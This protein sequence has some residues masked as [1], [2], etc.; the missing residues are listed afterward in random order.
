V[1]LP[2][3]LEAREAGINVLVS[4]GTPSLKIQMKKATKINARYVVMVGMMEAS[5]GI[6][7]VRDM[8]E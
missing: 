7:Q 1:V 2:L 8:L 5:T 4:L 6:Y 3:S